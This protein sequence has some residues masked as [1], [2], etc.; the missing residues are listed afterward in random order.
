MRIRRVHYDLTDLCNAGCPQCA[1]TDPAGC[2][3]KPWLKQQAC[4]LEDFRRF[5]PPQLLKE[6]EFA[7]FCGNF[8]DPA[9][10]PEMLE[11]LAYCWEA[12]PDLRMRL[13]SNCSVRSVAWWRA[14]GALARGRAFR[15]I[16]AI[17]GASQ[18]TNRRY[19]V[20]TDFDRIMENAGAFIAAGGEAEWWMLVFRHNEHETAAAE[21]LAAARGFVNFR[22]YPSNRFGGLKALTY[23]HR[24]EEFTLEPPTARHPPKSA[25]THSLDGEKPPETEVVIECEALRTSEAF[26]DFLGYLSPCCHIGRRIYMREQGAF[27]GPDDWM[28]GVFEGF[29][30]R[31]L[32]VGAVGYPA[33]R[34]AYEDFIE[35]L[36]PFW[37]ARQPVVCK[38]VCGRKRPVAA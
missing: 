1:R 2:M 9:V 22:A 30:P 27:A 19:R 34:A 6:I 28:A 29:D 12:N 32:N 13:Y 20:R 37:Q 17:D 18:E 36:R 7:Y 15:L 24:G 38:T 31:R 25:T 8:G 5:S 33:A 21:A 35:H 16:A 23:S 11:I 26:V 4:S 3:P 10:A 14:L